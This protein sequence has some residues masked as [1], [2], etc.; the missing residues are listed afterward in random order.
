MNEIIG[1][2]RHTLRHDLNTTGKQNIS[3]FAVNNMKEFTEHVA[4]SQGP[5]FSA[6]GSSTVTKVFGITVVENDRVPPGVIVALDADKKV[7]GI[8]KNTDK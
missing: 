5:F 6:T 4:E 2:M 1:A 7:I 8:I 3:T